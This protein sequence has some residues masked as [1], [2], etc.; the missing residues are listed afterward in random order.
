MAFKIK[1]KKKKSQRMY[2][3]KLGKDVIRAKTKKELYEKL[4]KGVILWNYDFK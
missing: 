1:P 3:L 4:D 2:E